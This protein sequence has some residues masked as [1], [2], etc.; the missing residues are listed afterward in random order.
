MQMF[1]TRENE[2]DK[3]RI[4]K[5]ENAD[6][7]AKRN[8]VSEK[9][10]LRSSPAKSEFLFISFVGLATVCVRES[11]SVPFHPHQAFVIPFVIFDGFVDI[12]SHPERRTPLLV[13]YLL[14]NQVW[15]YCSGTCAQ[16][17]TGSL[18]LAYSPLDIG[19]G[20]LHRIQPP[21]PRHLA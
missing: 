13:T 6:G 14:R 17:S 20:L 7:A 3:G 9:P 16:R 8:K 18:P 11:E 12:P 2:L 5:L 4:R 1:A 19:L 15:K 10:I 21:V